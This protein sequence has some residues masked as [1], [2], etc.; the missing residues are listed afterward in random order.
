MK[1]NIKKAIEVL[2]SGGIGIFPTD[3]AYGIGCR[4]DD[5][6]AVRRLFA[7]R[8][9][10]ETKAVP[11]LVSGL[12]MARIYWK[13]LSIEVEH[14][15]INKYWPGALTIILQSRIQKIPSLVRGGGD[16]LGLRMPDSEVLLKI[17]EEV[18]VP[19]IGTSANFAGNPTPYRFEELDPELIQ[20]VD[21]VLKDSG[22][23]IA[24]ASIGKQ[25]RMTKNKI[26]STVIDC[27]V[28]PWKILREGA[29]RID[30]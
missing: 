8:K 17:I 7:L 4:I 30:L 25:T 1:N 20:L 12:E 24:Q 18:G 13:E 16:T 29:I 5:E 2:K 26:A 9:R 3:T 28:T 11:V 15:L 21:Y 14:K 19:I 10:P 23:S 22:P 27:S 6:E